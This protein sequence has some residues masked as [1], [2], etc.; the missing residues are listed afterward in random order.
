MN[1]VSITIRDVPRDARDEIAARAARSGRSLQEH[2][3][4]HLIEWANKPS[5]D[6][7]L[8]RARERARATQTYLS[9]EEILG[10]RDAGRR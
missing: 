8:D 2:V 3:R 10:A 9:A 5:N 1:T 7:I 6:D 4:L